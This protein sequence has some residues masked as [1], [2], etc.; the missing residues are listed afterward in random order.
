M[1]FIGCSHHTMRCARQTHLFE[2]YL[3]AHDS[4]GRSLRLPATPGK[5]KFSLAGGSSFS[6][7]VLS[8]TPVLPG[9]RPG[10]RSA[11]S[12]V[13]ATAAAAGSVDVDAGTTTG[14]VT[15][16]DGSGGTRPAHPSAPTYVQSGAGGGDR[17]CALGEIRHPRSHWMRRHLVDPEAQFRILAKVG[18]PQVGEA[19]A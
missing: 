1:V 15:T 5:L 10:G 9:E 6:P 4:R 3:P 14:S 13:A 2:S 19:Y 7:S 8:Y 16:S 11:A 17:I 12:G 18:V